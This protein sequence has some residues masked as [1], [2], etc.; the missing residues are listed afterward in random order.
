MD[1]H[2]LGDVRE[3]LHGVEPES[4]DTL[5]AAISG[6]RSDPQIMLAPPVQ[7]QSAELDNWTDHNV[8]NAPCW[9]DTTSGWD[10]FLVQE[11]R[12]NLE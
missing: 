12:C 4:G 7:P 2:N 6:V 1:P 5:F 10:A 8:Y 11:E 3:I 9:D